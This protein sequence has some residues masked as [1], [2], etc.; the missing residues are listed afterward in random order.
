MAITR[1]RSSLEFV[2]DDDRVRWDQRYGD[3]EGLS[4][5]DVALPAVFQPFAETFPTAGHALDLACGRGGAAVWLA[6]RGLEVWGYDVSPVAI[7]QARGLAELAG[8]A[9]RCHFA[10]ID[11]DDG[12]PVGRPLDMLVCN[13][14][15]DRSLYRPI[16]DRLAAGGLLAISV[17]S[18]V[19]A[20]SGPFRAKAGELAQAFDGLAV[21]AAREADGHSWLLARR[22]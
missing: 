19:G 11:L 18:E 4:D 17:L 3:R 9:A 20:S 14:F 12:L 15:R 2:S 13:G 5:D 21:I 1:Q 22:G 6:Q 7:T 8:V 10:A 16:R